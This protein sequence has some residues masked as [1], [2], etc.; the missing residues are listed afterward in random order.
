MP[1]WDDVIAREFPCKKCKGTFRV[2]GPIDD[3]G[4]SEIRQLL[5][6]GQPISAIRRIRE[7]TDAE[8]RDAK[9]MYEH[10]TIFR[11]RCREC[12][13]PLPSGVLADCPQCGALNINA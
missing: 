13:L 3:S 5:E 8:L 6:S 4:L 11:G 9:G 2:P 10:V 12:S 7:L 1:T